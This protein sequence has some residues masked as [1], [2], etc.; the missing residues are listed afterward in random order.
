LFGK[1][2]GIV[3]TTFLS[4]RLGLRAPGGLSYRH[5]IV[6]GVAAA[7]GFTVA[8]FFATSA[9]PPGTVLDQA[10]MGALLSFFSAPIAIAVGRLFGVRP[11]GGYSRST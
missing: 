10:K 7:I 8:L 5:A 11:T 1:P 2:I 3:G 6:M 4:V 9:F